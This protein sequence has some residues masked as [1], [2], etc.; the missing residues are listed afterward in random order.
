MADAE[1]LLKTRT[2]HA[3]GLVEMVVW[4]VPQPVPPSGHPFKYRLVFAR[5]GQRV[6]GYDNERGKGDHKHIGETEA[7]SLVMCLLATVL[8]WAWA[9]WAA[10]SVA[11]APALAMRQG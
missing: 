5:G 4:R 7:G 8:A 2:V 9:A 10:H 6:V 11:A 3:G 1:L